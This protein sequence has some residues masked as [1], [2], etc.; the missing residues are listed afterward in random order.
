MA[1]SVI[2][3]ENLSKRYLKGAFGLRSFQEDVRR[4]VGR[5]TGRRSGGE[6]EREEFWALKEISFAVEEGEILGIVGHNGAGKST[7]LKI[8]ARITAPTSGCVRLRGRVGS[9]LEVGTG[10]H[11]ELSGRENVFLN[12][13]IL[14]MSRKEI[15]R[16]FDQIVDFSGVEAFLD[17]PVKRYSSGMYVRL[18]FAVAAHLDADILLMDE[19]LAVGDMAFQKKCLG[20]MGEV[21][22]AGR[23]VVFVSHN[24]DSIANLCQRLAILEKGRLEFVGEIRQGL[25]NY[26]AKTEVKSDYDP[27]LNS[28]RRV[29]EN[30][31]ASAKVRTSEDFSVQR[32]G[33]P[34]EIDFEIDFAHDPLRTEFSVVLINEER[35]KVALHFYFDFDL[36]FSA[37]GRYRVTCRIPKIRLYLGTYF[38][39]AYLLDRQRGILVDSLDGVCPFSV[40]MDGYRR[41]TPWLPG[42]CQ[43]V[44]D[45][46][47]SIRRA[48]PGDDAPPA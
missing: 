7:L 4:V 35:K 26:R 44:E 11:P 9:M 10:F 31:I 45:T 33:E 22:H 6:S 32:W 5:L 30:G 27:A 14:G 20:K 39:Q 40:V 47:W 3:I 43:Y 17:T 28:I 13:A 38:V 16:K 36:R 24:L 15:E 12:G 37:P 34:M 25:A 29:V 1:R 8:L 23:T 42:I 19:V 41:P 21:A 48:E 18:A 2:E 46:E